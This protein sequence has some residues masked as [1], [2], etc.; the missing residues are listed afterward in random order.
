MSSLGYYLNG[1]YIKASEVPSEVRVPRRNPTHAS[2]QLDEARVTFRR[3]FLQ[4]Y[5]P[6]TSKPNPEFVKAYPVESKEYFTEE[7][8][9]EMERP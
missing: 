6:G 5:L 9:K 7:Q 4:P 1:K 2:F 8:L 3:D